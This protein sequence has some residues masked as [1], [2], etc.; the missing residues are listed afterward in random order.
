MVSRSFT[1]MTGGLTKEIWMKI[2]TRLARETHIGSTTSGLKSLFSLLEY[3]RWFIVGGLVLSSPVCSV[4]AGIASTINLDLQAI[5]SAPGTLL[6]PPA[7]KKAPAI[8]AAGMGGSGGSGASGAGATS[9]P[10]GQAG[11]VTR[12]NGIAS[13]QLSSVTLDDKGD[14][15]EEE[16]DPPPTKKA[17]PESVVPISCQ[18]CQNTLN[19][20][21]MS[22]I[23]IGSTVES[24]LCDACLHS[25]A[26]APQ[27]IGKRKATRK[28]AR[29]RAQPAQ[30]EGGHMPL[31]DYTIQREAPSEKKDWQKNAGPS[32]SK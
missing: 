6:L 11:M 12:K 20:Q 22:R 1:R 28:A 9:K 24:V 4:H 26:Q 13:H 15:R 7:A 8:L 27:D 21:E 19:E 10:A 31:W 18:R 29:K 3:F 32:S 30:A 23:L 16:N 5:P 2:N 14:E 17:Q 25:V